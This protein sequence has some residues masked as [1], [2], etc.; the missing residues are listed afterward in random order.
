VVRRFAR[1]E[2]EGLVTVVKG[3]TDRRSREIRLTG[4]GAE[5]LQTAVEGWVNAQS[6]FESVFGEQ[7]SSELRARLHAVSASEPEGA[8]QRSLPQ[9]PPG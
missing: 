3:R 1:T 7:R 2:R 8:R 5:R 9:A 4:A 6:G